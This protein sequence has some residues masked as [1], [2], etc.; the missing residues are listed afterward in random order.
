MKD[1][2]TNFG[3]DAP[4]FG[5]TSNMEAPAMRLR[6]FVIVLAASALMPVLSAHAG[7]Y[8]TEASFYRGIAGSWQGPGEIVAGKYKG[9]RFTCSLNGNADAQYAGGIGISGSCR[10][11][12]FT[13]PISASVKRTGGG[14]SGKFLDGEA[15]DGMDVVGGRYSSDRLTVE[16]RRKD[17]RGVMA[18]RLAGDNKLNVTISVRVGSQL[19]PVIGMSLDRLDKVERLATSSV[20]ND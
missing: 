2:L 11:G 8:A 10:V 16:V 12:V 1:C 18:A 13:Q 20:F 6:N 3:N 14:F 5:P 9:T 7:T 17:L 15:G 19:I 4:T